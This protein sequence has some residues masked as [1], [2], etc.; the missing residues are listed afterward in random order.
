MQ[1]GIINIPEF[2]NIQENRLKIIKDLILLTLKLLV[3]VFSNTENK[4]RIKIDI[5]TSI[6]AFSIW[7][8]IILYL[9]FLIFLL[10]LKDLLNNYSNFQQIDL[11]RL[12]K[13]FLYSN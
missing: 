5:S 1:T 3:P 9:K 4:I 12:Y 13:V 8:L 7:I 6:F 10:E 2:K 11:T